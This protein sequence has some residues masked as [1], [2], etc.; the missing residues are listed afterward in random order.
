MPTKT[1]RR[2]PIEEVRPYQPSETELFPR[3]ICGEMARALGV[4]APDDITRLHGIL[5]YPGGFAQIAA[6]VDKCGIPAAG[7]RVALKELQKSLEKPLRLIEQL[8]WQSKENIAAGYAREKSVFT[9]S[10]NSTGVEFYIHRDADFAAMRRLA[11]AV[12]FAA[13]N[14]YTASKTRLG[15]EI[16]HAK[17][18]IEAYEEFSGKQ[19][20]GERSDKRQHDGVRKF[21]EIGVNHITEGRLTATQI[22]YV[23]RQ[24][25]EMRRRQRVIKF[26][27][28]DPS[29][30]G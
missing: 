2:T 30:D 14:L 20:S 17:F 21:L 28:N 4:D 7:Q 18:I 16:R 9:A 12:A 29:R 1:P 25:A 15:V 26:G 23:I 11:T 13:D 22:G 8:D 5:N 19:L 10:V 6:F 24:A 27:E 3:A